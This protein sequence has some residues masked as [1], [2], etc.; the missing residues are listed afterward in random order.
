MVLLAVSSNENFNKNIKLDIQDSLLKW[1]YDI[2]GSIFI[3]I[4]FCWNT[5]SLNLRG[6]IQIIDYVPTNFQTNYKNMGPAWK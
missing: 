5:F 2:L 4:L 3:F 6:R 1:Y